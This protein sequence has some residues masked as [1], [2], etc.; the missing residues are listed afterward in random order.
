MVAENISLGILSLP[1]AVA[2]LGMVPFVTP[3]NLTVSHEGN[4][5]ST[6]VTSADYFFHLTRAAILIVFLAL[7]SWY[8]GFVIGQFKIRYPHV[9]SMGDAGEILLGRFGRE[10]FG[11]GQLLLLIFLMASHILT[12]SI[13]MNALTDHGT[14]TIV[15]GLMGLVICLIGALPRTMAKV[16]WMSIVCESLQE[17]I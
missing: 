13:V 15:F 14:C 6:E 10:F 2:T 8:T 4:P 11:A 9:H 16:Y 7:L 3:S 17:R 5:L 12:F 1:S